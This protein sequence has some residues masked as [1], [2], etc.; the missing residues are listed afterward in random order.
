MVSTRVLRKMSKQPEAQRSHLLSLFSLQAYR[1]YRAYRACQYATRRA[2]TFLFCCNSGAPTVS[3]TATII[4]R[5]HNAA[6]QT[7]RSV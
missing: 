6:P 2:N 3:L 1:A 5:H 7:N 4:H